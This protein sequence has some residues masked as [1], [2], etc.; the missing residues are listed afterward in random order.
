MRPT[1]RPFCSGASTRFMASPR[2]PR[3]A[4]ITAKSATSSS[5][6]EGKHIMAKHK[7][8]QSA[9]IIHVKRPSGGGRAVAVA[10]DII[11][12]LAQNGIHEDMIVHSTYPGKA[13]EPVLLSYVRNYAVTPACGS[14][15]DLTVTYDNQPYA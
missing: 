6:W 9:S 5:E 1:A 14:W 8:T 3:R 10:D 4:A 7:L 2:S 11:H 13:T 15:N 12:V